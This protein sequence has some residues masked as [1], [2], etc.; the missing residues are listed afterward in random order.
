MRGRA[1]ILYCVCCLLWGSTW[2]VIKIGLDDLPPFLFGGIRMA[3]ASTILAPWV[4]R[5]GWP[6]VPIQRWTGMALVGLLQMG[7]SYAAVF[8]AER[9][10]A[11]GLT[12][13]LFCTY[14]IWVVGLAHHL[15]PDER[16]TAVHVLSAGLGVLGIAVLEAPALSLELAPGVALALFLPLAA[17]ISSA[18]GNVLQKRRLSGVPL[19]LNLWMQTLVGAVLLVSMHFALESGNPARWTPRA[20]GAVLYLAVLGTVVAF[21]CLFWLIPRVPMVVIGAIPVIDTVIAVALGSAVLHEPLGGRF[22]LGGALVLGGAA[23]ATRARRTTAAPL[24]VTTS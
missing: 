13:V 1:V 14:P 18:L 2:L 17:A 4:F 11:S 20:Y 19:S 24:R 12:A 10:I 8:A 16:L 21:L 23:L 22:L 5:Q 7:L 3:T 6:S 9:F 15:L